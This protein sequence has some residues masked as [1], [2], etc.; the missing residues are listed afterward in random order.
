VTLFDIPFDTLSNRVAL[1][2]REAPAHPALIQGERRVTYA[3]LDRLMDRVAAAMQRDDVAPRQVVAAIAGNSIEYIALYCGALRAGV[4]VAPLP[5]G[6]TAEQLRMMIADSGARLLFLDAAG[7]ERVGAGELPRTIALDEESFAA[8]LAPEGARPSPIDVQPD[9]PF[10]IIYSSGTTGTPKG[11]VQPHGMRWAHMQ[12]GERQMYRAD[13]VTLVA[14]PIYSNTSLVSIFSTLG[15]GGTLVL[16][17]KFDA[18]EWLRLA[19]RHRVTHAM[20]VPVMIQRIL[21]HADFDRTD[22]SAMQAKFSTGSQFP[23][24]LKAEVLKRWPGRMTDMYGLTEGGLSC[25]LDCTAFPDKLHTIGKPAPDADLRFIDEQ[26]REVARGELGELVGH[27]AG[28]MTGYFNQPQKTSDAEWR[29]ATGKRFIRSG[30]VGRMD[31]DGFV[32]LLDRRKDM[33]ISGGFNLYPVD[34]ENVLRGHPD[35]RDVS[36]IGVPSAEWGET[37]V[38]FVVAPGADAKMLKD[39][40]NERLGR[41]QRLHDVRLID[42]LPRNAPGKILK[43]ELRERYASG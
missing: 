33:I 3:G 42:E 16:M 28:M 22:L 2:A 25:A 9:W 30:D 39:W 29:D 38:A 4:A 37:P 13:T 8:W 14:V 17:A 5:V 21:A 34:L 32:T 19:A 20:L 40:A 43:R 27:S 7:A 23:A 35:V 36:V 11:I 18:G 10:N 6:A 26:G 1:R 41:M 12:R 31:A 15:L 24:Q